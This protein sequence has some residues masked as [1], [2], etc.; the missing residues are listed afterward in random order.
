V[1]SIIVVGCG[2]GIPLPPERT[3][4]PA[5][6]PTTISGTISDTRGGP[7][8]AAA[9]VVVEGTG[10]S[11][12][13][14]ADGSFAFTGAP[15]AG[16]YN[17]LAT[18]AGYG[19][20]RLQG[21]AVSPPDTTRVEMLMRPR[22]DPAKPVGPPEIVVWDGLTP[23]QTVSGTVTFMVGAAV[24]AAFHPMLLIRSIFV[25]FGHRGDM[26][27]AEFHD[28]DRGRVTWDT[29]T[30]GNGPTFINIIAYDNNHNVAEWNFP[31]TV[32]NTGGAVPGRPDLVWATAV[33]FGQTLGTFRTQREQAAAAGRLRGDPHLLPLRDGRSIDI[34]AAPADAS[35]FVY[36]MWAPAPFAGG[37]GFRVYRSF[38]AGGPFTLLADAGTGMSEACAGAL[39][40]ALA[41][42]YRD[43]S[44]ELA[45]GKTVYYRVS[46][47][48]AAGESAQSTTMSTT[49]LGRF[50]LNLTA[51]ANET[52]TIAPGSTPTFS[53]A[54]VA[55]VGTARYYEGYVVGV[56]DS[57]DTRW[58]FSTTGATSVTYGAPTPLRRSKRYEW[59]VDYAYAWQG[60]ATGDAYSMGGFR[61]RGSFPFVSSG[62]LN[63]P[64][65]FTTLGHPEPV[66]TTP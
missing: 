54:P 60:Y 33:T 24:P 15:G 30:R 36:V 35:L 11:T 32:S 18:K 21:V 19:A 25:R 56:N 26:A 20:S 41:R 65:H 58:S 55:T 47:Y 5:P 7:A 48:T 1:L 22:F 52:T 46:A 34:Q 45:A 37:K 44:P 8:V 43:S 38:S 23:G 3:P 31:V 28:A 6:G 66:R 14:G 59:D 4:I 13:T 64:F 62:S 39:F 12:T 9:T 53:W 61:A 16:T 40:P 10:L 2:E 29:T 49:P 27:N 17:L 50:N 42:C 63:G 51:P 57:W